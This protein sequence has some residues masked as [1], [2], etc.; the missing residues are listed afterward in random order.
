VV[1]LPVIELLDGSVVLLALWVV[2]I[3]ATGSLLLHDGAGGMA[4]AISILVG[5]PIALTARGRE[6][7]ELGS[8]SPETRRQLRVAFLAMMA[9]AMIG[10]VLALTNG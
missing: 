9:L 6:K 4:N 10:L 2:A 8:I 7:I 3:G 5:R 1:G